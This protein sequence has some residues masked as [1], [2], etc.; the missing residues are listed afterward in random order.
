MALLL[1]SVAAWSQP[2]SE[3]EAREV[4][5]R[6]MADELGVKKRPLLNMVARQRVSRQIRQRLE[7]P[8]EGYAL[9]SGFYVFNAEDGHGFVIVGADARQEE[10]LG[11]AA[12][13]SFDADDIPCGLAMLLE[14]YN[15]EYEGVQQ[16]G[17][18]LQAPR[19]IQT[20]PVSPLIKSEWGQNTPYNNYCP[21]DP[22][23]DK[24]SITGCVAT[25]MSQ[26]MY[27]HRYPS[28]PADSVVNY[29]S[30]FDES[31][32]IGLTKR[33]STLPLNWGSMLDI[34]KDVNYSSAQGNAVAALMYAAGLSVHMD[35]SSKES[36]SKTADAAYALIYFFGYN[37]NLK[38]VKKDYYSNETWIDMIQKELSA[39]RPIVYSGRT[40]KDDEGNSSGHAFILDGIDAS[41]RCHFN[42]GWN[43]NYQRTDAGYAYYAL[44]SVKPGSHNYSY[45]Q[46]MIVGIQKETT[47]THEMVFYADEFKIEGWKQGFNVGDVA[48]FACPAYCYDSHTNTYHTPVP[49]YLAFGMKDATN[50]EGK[51]TLLNSVTNNEYFLFKNGWGSKGFKQNVTFDA[52][53]FKEGGTYYLYPAVLNGQKNTW[54]NIHTLGAKSDF[55]V[56][57][58]KNGK[59][60]LGQGEVPSLPNDSPNISYVSQT[61]SNSNLSKMKPGDRI[62]L[63]AVFKNS[64]STVTTDTRVRIFNSDIQGV[65]NTSTVS[66]EFKGAGA[67]T[68]VD[69]SI[70]LPELAD[71]D[72]YATIQFY[73]SWTDDPSW[74]Y[75]KDFLVPFTVSTSS[76]STKEMK[77]TT[78]AA[79]YAT[80]Y[81]S[82]TSYTLPSGLTAYVVSSASG[83]TLSYTSIAK[84]SQSGI[85]PKGVPV[86]LE[87]GSST[88]YT[89][90]STTQSASYTGSN[91]L[92]GSDMST[93]TTASGSGYL[94]YKLSY[95]HSSSAYSNVFGWYWGAANG[96]AFTIGGHKAWLAVKESSTRAD[97]FAIDETDGIE[98][99]TPNLSPLGEGSRYDL[100]GRRIT[101]D[102]QMPGGVII[103]NGKKVLVK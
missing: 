93:T 88:T 23:T 69:L 37:K 86:M 38:Y 83:G 98:G 102:R 82:S 56:A 63:T 30:E 68:Q 64:G 3:S 65:T 103:I 90:V 6:F 36:S 20:T 27:Y 92:R 58:V 91:L 33:L 39:G 13:G 97:F 72:Y 49:C 18:S 54:Y 8:L 25:A 14:Q 4:A 81:D 100:S 75:N 32:K 29:V 84:G 22:A 15:R 67:Q 80:F 99:L 12:E 19:R 51:L 62:S 94:F 21:M 59:I 85:V 5:A 55:Y 50:L 53:R 42:F 87:G 52:T 73:R 46:K 24:R 28:S 43:G 11:Y 96:G 1:S 76:S 17:T 71:G 7:R 48:V 31:R 77:V 9:G 89:L 57:R 101:S 74:R 40:P 66:K 79:G 10:I 41:G 47:G 34:Y 95:G 45:E 44:S 61:S 60:Y 78:S 26:I 2:R 70:T 16:Q 35:Y